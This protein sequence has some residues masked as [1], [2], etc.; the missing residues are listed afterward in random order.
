MA[1]KSEK[2]HLD[3]YELVD[4]WN[5]YVDWCIDEDTVPELDGEDYETICNIIEQLFQHISYQQ[6]KIARF[7][8]SVMVSLNAL[9]EDVAGLK[10]RKR[11]SED[12]EPTRAKRTKGRGSRT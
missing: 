2:K 10:N 5:W 7:E 4:H 1:D 11:K 6:D 12:S 3:G 8:G 9:K